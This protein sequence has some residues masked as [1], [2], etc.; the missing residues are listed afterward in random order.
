MEPALTCSAGLSYGACHIWR[1]GRAGYC[2]HT[3]TMRG[4][5]FQIHF[6]QAI[7]D[8]LQSRLRRTRAVP[9]IGSKEWRF[10]SNPSYLHGLLDYW[11]TGFDWRSQ[12]ARLN[13]LPQFRADLD[14]ARIH[15]VHMA[16][17]G[18]DAMPLLL[19][20]GWPDSF[21][22]YSKVIPLLTDAAF[23]VVVPSLPG[24]PLTGP[25][26]CPEGIPVNR[27]TAYLLWRLMT[28]TLGYERFA[29][30][31][32]D[33]GSVLAQL[34]AIAH[35][36]AVVGI[37]LTDIGWHATNV[38]P[39]GL[40]E[41]E[42]KFLAAAGKNFMAD[43]AYAAVQMS[44]PRS[45]AV[46]L[47]DSPAGLAS[48]IVDRF[49]SWT[50]ARIENDSGISHDDLLTNIMLYWATQTI[51]SSIFSYFA[52]AQRPSLTP[53][54]YVSRP[55]G[56][57]LFPKDGAAAPPRSFADRTLNVQRYT[58]M[59]R[60]GHFAALEEPQ[61]FAHDV[62][63]FFAPLREAVAMPVKSAAGQTRQVSH[64]S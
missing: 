34:L 60:G 52:E 38:E 51:G 55:V 49:H 46:G 63:Q 18:P 4:I 50:D 31:G 17:R 25:V 9:D 37:H 26:R 11:R 29:I 33:G 41:A 36:A 8:D 28:Q 61:L 42:K 27:H 39:S 54:D 64:A 62:E 30:A 16:G 15:F 21:Y 44:Q 22:R 48:W 7:L 23:D 57:A 6:D 5:P 32:G 20:H 13:A 43:G 59:P 45:L 1:I 24:F 12:E 19:L 53:A 3:R 14:G 35:P 40:S 56:L 47:N 10:G 58:P 2:R